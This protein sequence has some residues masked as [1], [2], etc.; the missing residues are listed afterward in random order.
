MVVRPMTIGD[1]REVASLSNQLGYPSS[2]S[3]IEK[4]LGRM[5]EGAQFGAFVAEAT[6]GVI[7]GWIHVFGVR[8]LQEDAFAEISG[9]VV[10]ANSQGQ[11]VGKALLEVAEKWARENGYTGIYVR[12]NTKRAEAPPFYKAMGYNTVKTQNVFHKGL[13]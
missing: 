2:E 3:D 1:S 7:S 5:T 9:L 4:R 10:A 11:G 12:A 13:A 8:L 6:E